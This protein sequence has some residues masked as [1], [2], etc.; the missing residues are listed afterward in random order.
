M[1]T[2]PAA[3]LPPEAPAPAG[4]DRL[5]PGKRLDDAVHTF[6]VR[7]ARKN[8]FVRSVIPYTGYG[9]TEW[10]RILARVVLAK[11]VEEPPVDGADALKPL[12]ESIRGWRNFTNPAVRSEEAVIEIQGRAHTVRADDGGI[13]DVRL[14]VR[15]EPGWHTVTIRSGDSP[16]VEA[17]VRVVADDVTFGVV[18]DVDDTVMVTALP[19]PF[20]AAWNTFVLDEHARTPTPGMAVLLER[21]TRQA[22]EA[23]VLY[24]STG[25]WNVAATLTRFLSRNLYP[26]GPKLLTDWG[27]TKE[28]WFRSG[29]EHKRTSL[30]RLASDFPN[31][32]WLLIGDDGQHDEAIYAEFAERHPENV[33][34]IAIRQLSAGEA[35][36]AGGRS[37]SDHALR[38]PGVPW[39]YAPDGAG[40]SEQLA[41]LGVIDNPVQFDPEE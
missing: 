31:I 18:S 34:A 39:V 35:V 26:A 40:M 16:T 3:G 15:F 10:V 30:E 13:I 6:R 24:L 27:P 2:S 23:P 22:P 41:E 1:A 33:R 17:P 7:R 12:K 19:R 11:P 14:P 38:S 9:T 8:G 28:R 4:R 36:L 21:I 5:H 37:H 20:L 32:K 29:P 25:A